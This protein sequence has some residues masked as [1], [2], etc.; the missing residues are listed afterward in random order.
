MRIKRPELKFSGIQIKSI[1][2]FKRFAAAAQEIE[3]QTGIHQVTIT[4]EDIFF[5]PWID[6]ESY[7]GTHMERLLIGLIKKMGHNGKV[8]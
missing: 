1:E 6:I 4:L 7:K 2:A 3:E 8:A 5:C